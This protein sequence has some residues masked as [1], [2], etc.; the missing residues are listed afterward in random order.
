[1]A[2]PQVRPTLI[3]ESFSPQERF[4]VEKTEEV[5]VEKTEEAIHDGV[6]LERLTLG[7]WNPEAFHDKVDVGMVAQHARVHQALMDGVSRIWNEWVAGGC[8]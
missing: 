5:L 8:S 6:Q 1:M 3:P 4:L 2:S 7:W